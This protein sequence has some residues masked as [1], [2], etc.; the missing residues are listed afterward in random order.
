VLIDTEFSPN[1]W[2]HPRFGSSGA[3]QILPGDA[4]KQAFLTISSRKYPYNSD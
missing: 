4:V 3:R 1:S 2:P